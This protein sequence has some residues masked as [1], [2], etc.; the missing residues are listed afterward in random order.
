MSRLLVSLSIAALG[1]AAVTSTACTQ[2]TT[3]ITIAPE[4]VTMVKACKQT[5][6]A[7]NNERRSQDCS[8]CESECDDLVLQGCDSATVCVSCTLQPCTDDA[9]DAICEKSE[10]TT[11]VSLRATPG[12]EDACLKAYADFW[13]Q[14]SAQ[15]T[16][17]DVTRKDAR[18][19]N[20]AL[21]ESEAAR[22]YY[23][24]VAA[25]ECGKPATDCEQP[26][27]LG[28]ELCAMR[29]AS[30][31]EAPC[32]DASRAGLNDIGSH[33]KPA[34]LAAAKTCLSQTSCDDVA[35]CMREWW[36]LID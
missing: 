36:K 10:W 20:A 30:C 17:D 32:D 16:E 7:A 31:M 2:H 33:L 29:G 1:L 13:A 24:C 21:I 26:S 15:P 3:V 19:A 23:A 35:G 9:A 12:V 34:M 18:C 25:A 28:D 27:T 8:R 5:A 22:P 14:C 6:C 4:L 11:R